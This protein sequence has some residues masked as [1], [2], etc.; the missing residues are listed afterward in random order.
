MGSQADVAADSDVATDALCHFELVETMN[1]RLC[2]P[3]L[4]NGNDKIS[5]S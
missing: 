2:F 5:L 1:F 4:Q 3:N